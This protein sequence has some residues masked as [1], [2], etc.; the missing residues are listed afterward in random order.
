[1]KEYFHSV[2]L[3]KDKCK[4]CTNCIKRCPTQAIRVRDSKAHIIDE[5]CIDCGECIKTCPYHAKVAFTDSYADIGKYKYKIALPSPT[6]Y[7]QFKGL[8]DVEKVLNG[9]MLMGFDDVF[10]VAVGADI[11]TQ[12]THRLMK[13]KRIRPVISSACPTVVRLIQ[14]RFPELIENIID[15]SSP[16]EVAAAVAKREFSQKHHVP[17]EEIGAFFI[18]PCP[19]KVTSIQNPLG[20]EKSN[21]DGALS[22]VDIYGLLAG[23]LKRPAMQ[24]RS[25]LRASALGVGWAS[26]G[27]ES[28]SLHSD[29]YL[30]VHGVQNIIRVLGE[31]ENDKLKDLDFFE[32]L[33]CTGGCVGGALVFENAYVARNRLRNL[34]KALPEETAEN[35]EKI[36]QYA[37]MDEIVKLTAIKPREVLKL[38]EDLITAMKKLEKVEELTKKLPGL[39]CGFCG[40]PTCRALAE[41]IVRGQAKELDCVLLLKE[42]VK[43]LAEEMVEL[44]SEDKWK[45]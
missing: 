27:G 17:I 36:E 14:V 5:L 6:L 4:G 38:D 34:R 7:G 13:E 26:S 40:S 23:Q 42:K 45:E 2:R 18:T 12:A 30:S 39:D 1:M 29:N 31:I 41:D 32:G 8:T 11:V 15:V 16:M 10:E 24:G 3:I 37:Q 43:H 35:R 25:T 44:A 21:V 9:L 28:T 19:A 22:I 33:A 20:R